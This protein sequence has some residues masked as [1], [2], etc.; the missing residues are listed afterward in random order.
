V[1]EKDKTIMTRLRKTEQPDM[2]GMSIKDL[3]ENTNDWWQLAKKHAQN[4][5]LYTQ[6]S[7]QFGE[8]SV[9]DDAQD[10]R[11]KIQGVHG[12]LK[13]LLPDLI[14]QCQICTS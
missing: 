5:E 9:C 7:K 13:S 12:M 10:Y 11:A 2:S 6:A 14:V 1:D 3:Q 8:L 4:E